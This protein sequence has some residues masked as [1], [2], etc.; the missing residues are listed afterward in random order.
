[1]SKR[2]LIN[3][4][5]ETLLYMEWKYLEMLNPNTNEFYLPMEI[6]NANDT[7]YKKIED[8]EVRHN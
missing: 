1:M 6:Q 3:K 2:H 8:N 5:L 4:C 7:I